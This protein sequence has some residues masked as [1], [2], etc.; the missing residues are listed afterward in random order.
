MLQLPGRLQP[1][2]VDVGIAA[3][4]VARAAEVLRVGRRRH[5]THVGT[6]EEGGRATCSGQGPRQ[7]RWKRRQLWRLL[8]RVLLV[9][10]VGVLGLRLA[11]GEDVYEETSEEQDVLQDYDRNK[12]GGNLGPYSAGLARDLPDVEADVEEPQQ[13]ERGRRHHLWDEGAAQLAAKL[14]A[15]QPDH[16]Q[17]EERSHRED[18]HAESK[19]TPGHYETALGVC[20]GEV[21]AV[22]GAAVRG[23]PLRRRT[24][25]LP[26]NCGDG[27]RQAYAD[28]NVHGVAAGDVD[29]RSVCSLIALRRRNRC[30]E[31][32]H[33]GAKRHKGDCG[34]GVLDPCD[35]AKQLCKVDHDGREAADHC[36]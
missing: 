14:Q 18:H 33:G 12:N 24:H 15:A 11:G 30:K 2:A 32:R 9:I 28:K 10:R 7:R 1:P 34:D 26:V 27:P 19:V 29:D 25:H 21:A 36:E 5:S 8:L 4:A 20:Q 22:L 23:D 17:S 13:H 6:L 3:H 31:V 35:A 16:G